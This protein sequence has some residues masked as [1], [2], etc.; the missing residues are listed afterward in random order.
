[1]TK[2]QQKYIHQVTSGFLFSLFSLKELPMV[3]LAGIR[4]KELDEEHS[5][6]TVKH[7]YLTKNPFGSLYFACLAMAAEL[8]S[9]VIAMMHVK[10]ANPKVSMLVTGTRAEFRKKAKGK[11]SFICADGKKIAAV[12][13]E[14]Q[15]TGEGVTV[16]VKAIGKDEQGDVVAEFIFVW[17]FKRKG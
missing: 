16:E 17:S 13:A 12:I 11:I 10:D 14:T 1:M 6:T 5:V 9:G 2:Q 4:V 7:G 3:F 8:S 15:N